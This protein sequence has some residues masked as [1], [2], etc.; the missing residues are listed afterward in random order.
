[1]SPNGTGPVQFCDSDIDP[2]CPVIRTLDR[3]LQ[4][5]IEKYVFFSTDPRYLLE[6]GVFATTKHEQ[7]ILDNYAQHIPKLMYKVE[8]TSSFRER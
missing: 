6:S 5:L 4:R 3:V 1:M 2:N 7:Y 8:Y